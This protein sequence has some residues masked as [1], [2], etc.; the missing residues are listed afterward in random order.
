MEIKFHNLI[1]HCLKSY[2]SFHQVA[3]LIHWVA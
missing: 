3:G 2:F 1:T